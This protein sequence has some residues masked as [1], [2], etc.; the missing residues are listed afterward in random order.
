MKNWVLG[1]I[2]GAGVVLYTL[3]LNTIINFENNKPY[4]EE[5]FAENRVTQDYLQTPQTEDNTLKEKPHA[6]LPSIASFEASMGVF[7]TQNMVFAEPRKEITTE[8]G[9][10]EKNN[11]LL[12][13]FGKIPGLEEEGGSNSGISEWRPWS[14]FVTDSDNSNSENSSEDSNSDSWFDNTEKEDNNSDRN[15]TDPLEVTLERFLSAD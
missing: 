2:L 5:T 7:N 12:Y 11:K 8:G 4:V 13:F 3:N 14:Q 15:S 9:D 10:T 1:L 6:G